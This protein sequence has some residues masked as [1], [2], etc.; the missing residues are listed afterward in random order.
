MITDHV[1]IV[2]W[3]HNVLAREI[4][5][6]LKERQICEVSLVATLVLAFLQSEPSIDLALTIGRDLPLLAMNHPRTG[7]ENLRSPSAG[8]EALLQSEDFAQEGHQWKNGCHRQPVPRQEL[9]V[10][11]RDHG[12]CKILN[13]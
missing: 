7:Y 8:P 11:R 9:P 10:K 1:K 3:I 13:Q 5:Q 12:L 6:L 2:I 4:V